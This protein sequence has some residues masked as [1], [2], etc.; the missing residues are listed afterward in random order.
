MRR[1]VLSLVAAS[2]LGA[3]HSAALAQDAVHFDRPIYTTEAAVLCPRQGDITA[4]R[5]AS[6]DS[7]RTAFERIAGRTCKTVGPDIRLSVVAKPGIYDPDV[8]VRVAS[9]PDLDPSLPRGKLWTLKTM[10]S[11]QLSGAAVNGPP[12]ALR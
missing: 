9:A 1:V 4:L 5:R 12:P 3:M 10:L 8:E 2:S 7:D 6:E 11:N